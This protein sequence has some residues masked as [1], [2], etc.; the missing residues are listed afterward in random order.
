ME[1]DETVQGHFDLVVP[2]CNKEHHGKFDHP[3]VHHVFAKKEGHHDWKYWVQVKTGTF[4]NF[5]EWT[6][7]FEIINHSAI[8]E[9]IEMGF[10]TYF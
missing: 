1:L 4:G 3:H 7:I 9:K 2:L 10:H 5:H 6:V 8:L